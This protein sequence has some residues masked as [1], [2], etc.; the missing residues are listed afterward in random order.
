LDCG[1]DTGTSVST[2]YRVPFTFT[3]G[4]KH[5]MIHLTPEK[6]S[7]TDDRNRQQAEA[8]MVLAR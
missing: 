3:G 1:E 5:V 6:L 8:A 7:A 2:D 4:L